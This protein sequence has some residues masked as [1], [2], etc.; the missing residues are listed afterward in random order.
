MT[1]D[2]KGVSQ[3]SS[4]QKLGRRRLMTLSSAAIAGGL[5]GCAGGKKGKKESNGDSNSSSGNGNLQ[6]PTIDTFYVDLPTR[7]T[8]NPWAT[9]Y[10][11]TLSWMAGEP[12]VRIFA[13]G[14][15]KTPLLKDWNYDAKKNITTLNFRKDW[16]WWNGNKVTAADK[17]WFEET[18]RLFD[19]DG[20]S[21]RKIEM[22][23]KFTLKRYHKEKQNPQLLK[24]SLGGYLGALVRG[25]REKYKPWAEKLKDVSSQSERDKIQENM[26]KEMKIPTQTVID[27]GLGLG[28]FK[29]TDFSAQDMTWEKFDKHPFADQINIP[30][31][32]Y[33]I[34]KEQ[35]LSQ[36]MTANKLDFGYGLV[37]EW[38]GKGAAPDNLENVGVHRSTYL[39]KLAINQNGDAKK[40]LRKRKVRQALAHV[41]NASNI[42]NNMGGKNYEI[43]AQSGLPQVIAKKWVG[44][45]Q[46]NKYINYSTNESN[47]SK[48][49]S[50]LQ[51]AGYQ[52]KGGNWV[53]PDG[54]VVTFEFPVQDSKV[55]EGKTVK[56]QLQQFG[57]K[58]NFMAMSS[59]NFTSKY[60]D[61]KTYDLFINSHGSLTP[62]PNSYFRINHGF[63][64]ELGEPGDVQRW[65]DQSKKYSQLNGRVLKPE[66]PKKVGAT[67]L[68]G[69]TK[70]VN[71]YKL[72]KEWQ[73]AQTDE[74]NKEIAQ[75]FSWF[76]N[77]HLP[78][79]DLWQEGDGSFGDT[80]SFEFQKTDQPIWQGYRAS[81]RNLKR[82]N[83]KSVSK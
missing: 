10:P 80:E 31:L 28:P 23:D 5:A 76:W 11:W 67:D 40:H 25:Y 73:A 43:K 65:L 19:P 36:K 72:W 17:Y 57:F 6:E 60:E 9:S 56:D 42:I 58:V 29:L 24:Y 34:A 54:D 79:I 70:K 32:K 37:S 53:G 49:T 12:V 82:G 3:P 63:G 30:T 16:Y 78:Q 7:M 18:A 47:T 4:Y 15:T 81:Y 44:Q 50:L 68:S 39:H 75:T 77:F 71:L 59:N 21:L 74:R 26:T 69:P 38:V 27:E 52:K 22:P 64:H 46:L 35:A 62:H 33:Q 55:T 20:S 1:K 66:I 8:W 45:D 14:S 61:N 41:I 83:I 13:D 48:A 2:S 51:S